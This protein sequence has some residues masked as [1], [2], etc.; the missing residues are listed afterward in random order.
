MFTKPAERS[1]RIARILVI[2]ILVF[3]LL[4]IGLLVWA[5]RPAVAMDEALGAL[6]SDGQVAVTTQPWLV[7][8]PV[9]PTVEAGFIFYPG[10]RVDPRA[11]APAAR[12][13]AAEGY[14]VV[15]P[16][17]PLNLAVFAPNRAQEVMTA[18]PAIERWAIG[19]HSLGGAMAAT[20]VAKHR[21]TV[22]TLVLWASYPGKEDALARRD[23]LAVTLIYGTRDGLSTVAKIEA[24]RALLPPQ[25]TFVAIEGGNHSQFGWYDQQPGDNRAAIARAA[26]QEQIVAATLAALDTK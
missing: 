5:G 19:G 7:F 21:N 2:L 26:Q 24:A 1:G 23:N 4:F 18:Y 20:F 15:I 22:D 6:M 10:G 25:T 14:L 9:T 13:I 8:A 3:A 16:P 17:M 11:Y 12:A